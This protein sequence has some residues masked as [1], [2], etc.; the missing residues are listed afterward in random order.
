MAVVE[1]NGQDPTMTT[2]AFNEPKTLTVSETYNRNL[3]CILFGKPGFYPSQPELGM[4]IGKYLYMFEDDIDTSAIRN[5]LAQQC[6]DFLPDMQTGDLDVLVT[7]Y[8]NKPLLLFKLPV[9]VDETSL[10][11]ILGITINKHGELI[12]RFKEDR[13]QLI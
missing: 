8:E 6:S 13:T 10:S 1:S 4:D 11:L 3:L 9:I 2:N 5:E 7:T 12:Y